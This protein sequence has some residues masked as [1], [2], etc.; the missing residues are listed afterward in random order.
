MDLERR[1]FCSL[2][3]SFLLPKR[4]VPDER[5]RRSDAGRLPNGQQF[6]FQRSPRHALPVF[7]VTSAFHARR[8]ESCL[9][10]LR[11]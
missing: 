10:I 4:A 2:R 1:V 9:S 7:S 5:Y 11:S 3:D 6:I 8:P